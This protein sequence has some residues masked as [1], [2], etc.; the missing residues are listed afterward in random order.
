MDNK[1]NYRSDHPNALPAV[2][3][4][5]RVGAGEGERIIEDQLRRFKTNAMINLV[6]AVFF[7]NPMSKTTAMPRVAT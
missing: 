3:I 7:R 1:H 2:A 4:Q 5:M 6:D